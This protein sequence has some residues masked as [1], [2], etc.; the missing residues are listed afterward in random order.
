MSTKQ[1][2]KTAK[3]KQRQAEAFAAF[4]RAHPVTAPDPRMQLRHL[5]QRS[6]RM[7]VETAPRNEIFAKR[8][9][10]PLTSVAFKLTGRLVEGLERCTC[11]CTAPTT[12]RCPQW[13]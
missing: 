13:R 10:T 8:R 3:R 12:C 9:M 7:I 4:K 11:D 2:R 6:K 1:S 5:D